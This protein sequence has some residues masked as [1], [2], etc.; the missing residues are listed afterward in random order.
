MSGKTIG[1]VRVSTTDQSTARQLEGIK[2]D[3]VFED[4]QAAKI[5]TGQC[6]QRCLIT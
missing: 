5:Q 6:W 4:K 2:L 1:Y 3:K